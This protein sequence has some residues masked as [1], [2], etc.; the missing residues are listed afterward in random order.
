LPPGSERCPIP[1]RS[2]KDDAPFIF[3]GGS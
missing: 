3:L 1:Q 2:D